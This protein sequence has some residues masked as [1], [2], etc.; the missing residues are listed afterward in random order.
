MS[1]AFL[2]A[3][4][5]SEPHT[6]AIWGIAWTAED[7][8]ISI[9]A[10]GSVK[11]WAA[12]SGQPHPPN[13]TFPAAHTLAQVSLSV[14]PDGKKALYNSIEGLTSLW[15]LG[16]GEVV[17]K[18]ESYARTGDAEPSWSVSLSPNGETYA[19]TGGSG[20]VFIHSAQPSNFGER[21]TTIPSGRPKFGM[22][23]KHSPDGRRVALSSE[24]GQIYIFDLESNSLSMTF[25]SHAMAVRSVAWS[26]DSTLLLSASEDKRLVLHDVRTAPGGAV[27]SFSGHS[28]W[29]L[30]T[31]ISADSRLGL[32]GSA[33]KTIKVWDIGARA[34]VSTIQDTGEVWSVCWRPKLPAA[35]SVGAFV[36]G[37]EDG[38]V[39]WWRGAGGGTT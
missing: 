15:D 8:V 21:L 23:C 31:D 36:S 37:G 9:S 4:D 39:R 11:Q 10:D 28:S 12:A 35:G 20:N 14:S 26:P 33:D 19:S 32:S 7:T 6:D 17:S 5:C 38:V 34:A 18:F 30:S 1:L 29:V 27:A 3:H 22:F 2:H 13:A 24:T 25:T 16:S